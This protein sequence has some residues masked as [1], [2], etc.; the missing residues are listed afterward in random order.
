VDV[1]LD[2]RFPIGGRDELE[3]AL[4]QAI[5]S[6]ALPAGTEVPSTRTLAA[7][8]GVARGTV[9]AALDQLAVEGLVEIRHGART[10]VRHVPRRAPAVA[11][12]PAATAGATTDTNAAARA[13]ADFTGGDP[14]LTQFPAS[15]WASAVRR[16]LASAPVATLGYGDPRGQPV[17]R[18]ALARYLRRTRGVVAEPERI[19]VTAG[20][21]GALAIVA[22]A[23]AGSGSSSVAVEDPSLW[24]HRSIL[25]RS[26]LAVT[27][28][29]V[30]ADGVMTSAL[31]ASAVDAVVVTPAHQTPTGVTLA[32][33]RRAALASWAADRRV[34][35]IE[36]DYDGELRYDRRPVPAL[37]ALDTSRI[38]YAGTASKSLAPG[39]RI[40]WAV[41][42]DEWLDAVVNVID[43]LGGSPVS[44]IEQ[45]ALAD[46][47]DSGR[48]DR[49]VRSMRAAYRRR[50]DDLVAA[51]DGVAS[52]V[53][54]EGV[55]AGLNALV[56][57]PVDCD[58]T[59]VVD[60]LGDDGVLV[61]PLRRFRVMSSPDDTP[62]IVVNYGAPYAH[63]IRDDIATLASALRHALA[64]SRR[65]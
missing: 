20:F 23:L 13:V 39:L 9:G 55:A 51:L 24:V 19:V 60:R 40:G 16:A 12:E 63:R 29:P 61:T 35:V 49:H 37:Q 62:G 22:R 4:R 65:R 32:P 46:L 5:M 58:E 27:P 52:G 18:E 44:A 48:Y 53:R 36:D 41:V 1:L 15:W 8:L 7:E 50:R 45:L 26:G 54:V 47:V 11:L 14:D 38:L 33:D 6:G 56:R 28:I 3:H 34:L 64:G 59:A 21:S 25:G 43:T 57:L 42:P 17:L 2:L 30:D 10:R 31:A